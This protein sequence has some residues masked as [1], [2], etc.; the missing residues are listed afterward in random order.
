M[1]VDEAAALIADARIDGTAWADL[2]C[3]DGVFT[4]ALATRLPGGSIIHAMDRD[5]SA[6]RAMPASWGHASIVTHAGDFT[7]LPL[8]FD[9][10]DGVLMANT[11]HYVAD[12][13]TWLRGC[14][15]ALARRR[16]LVVEY[17]TDRANPWIPYPMGRA[18]LEHL[19]RGAAYRQFDVVGTRPSIYH[20]AAI[21][22]A[23]IEGYGER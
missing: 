2:G 23:L 11:L 16:F 7:R 1:T 21:Y 18:A 4:R 14:E 6:L 17:D 9:A 13:Q 22:V 10:L 5:R 20:R 15:A 8:P 19:F 12:P 3:G